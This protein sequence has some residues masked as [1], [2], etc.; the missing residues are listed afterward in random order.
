[1]ASISV[2]NVGKA[3]K[4]YPSRLARIK[5]WV[6]PGESPR[7]HLHWVLRNV[8]FEVGEGETV[9]LAGANGAGKSTLLK[10]I[11][12]I[13]KPTEGEII[14]SG[15]VA[16]LL[17]LGMGFHPEFTGRQNLFMAGQI[18][19]M[20][21]DEIQERMPEIEA[22]AEIG[23][24]IDHPIRTYSS[25]MQVRLAFS[26]ATSRRPDLLI[27]DE[28][29]SV[30]DAYFQHKSFDRI[31]R[32]RRDGTTLLIV[33]HNR[34]AIQSICDRA[35]LLDKGGIAMEGPTEP[36]M[37]YYH[38]LMSDK[39]ALTIRQ[40]VL[41]NGQVQTISG[42]GEVT[43]ET[44]R[45]IRSDGL[46][47]ESIQVGEAV[48]LEVI[49]EVKSN[50]DQ[51]TL[52]FMIKDKFGQPVYGIN[53]FRVNKTLKDLSAGQ[54][55]R[56]HFDFCMN[57]GKGN[58]SVAFCLSEGDSHLARNYEWRDYGLVFQ[59]Y[60]TNREDFVGGTWLNAATHVQIEN[61]ETN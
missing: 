32:F 58:Y 2:K 11:V 60:N 52:G 24:A 21:I 53:T 40:R 19:G 16:A 39:E 13:L 46:S 47:T 7:H 28:A 4:Q 42:T 57:L 55:V 43:L 35:I 54:R 38:A 26:L 25:G 37:D 48:R 34:F 50:V 12:G 20:T 6:H 9:G 10:M 51:L 44:I 29:L 17:E 61:R 5:D 1:M 49:A 15:R 27:V 8:S 22:F 3:Y 14:R 31:Q 41:E 59:V 33:S 56:F 18:I 45:L 23:E 36:V 30:G